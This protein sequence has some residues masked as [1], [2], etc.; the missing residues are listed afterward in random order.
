[1]RESYIGRVREKFQEEFEADS[2]RQQAGGSVVSCPI[3]MEDFDPEHFVFDV[4]Q[5]NIG[6]FTDWMSDL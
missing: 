5:I 6:E 4:P 3:Q 2:E 1:M